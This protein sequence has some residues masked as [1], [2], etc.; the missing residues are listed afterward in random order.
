MKRNLAY[1]LLL[2]LFIT[3]SVRSADS[4]LVQDNQLFGLNDKG[5][6]F[7]DYTYL[8]ANEA[9]TLKYSLASV[10]LCSNQLG[11]LTGMRATVVQ[12][13]IQ[14]GVL[15]STVEL[16][17]IGNVD[18]KL[19]IICRNLTLDLKAKEYIANMTVFWSVAAISQI[20]FTTNLNRTLTSGLNL[21]SGTISSSSIFFPSSYG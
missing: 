6:P 13:N 9:S 10:Q 15:N 4:C 3:V 17:A 12:T 5:T 18:P 1:K 14:T 2:G 11:T 8:S 19:G 21:T 7:S 20:R 16:T